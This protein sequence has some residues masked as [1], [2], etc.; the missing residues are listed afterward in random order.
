MVSSTPTPPGLP[1]LLIEAARSAAVADG[2]NPPIGRT[3]PSQPIGRTRPSQSVPPVTKVEEMS[4]NGDGDTVAAALAMVAAGNA[5]ATIKAKETTSINTLSSTQMTTQTKDTGNNS[6]KMNSVPQSSLNSSSLNTTNSA[7]PPP[8]QPPRPP[9]PA[10]VE[11]MP[12]TVSNPPSAGSAAHRLALAAATTS[13]TQSASTQ[14]KARPPPQSSTAPVRSNT[15]GSGGGVSAVKKKGPALRRGKWTSEEEAYANRLIAEFKGG[16]LPL[17]DGTT[18]R[19]FLSK[20][21]NCDPMRIS[22][23]FVGSNCI[24]KQVFRR[25]T[26][27]INRLTPEQIQQSRAELSELERRFLERVAQTNRLKSSGVGGGNSGNGNVPSTGSSSSLSKMKG[28]GG[29][30]NQ[31]ARNPPWLRTPNGFKHG[32]GATAATSALS[33]GTVNRA[34]L[35]GRAMLQTSGNAQANHPFVDKMSKGP[36]RSSGSAGILALMEMQRRQSQNN[37]LPNVSQSLGNAS[38]ASNLL[39]EAAAAVAES[40]KNSNQGNLSGPALAQIARNASAA[41]MAGL[42]AAGN[43]MT[44][45]MLKTGLSRNQLSQLAREHQRNSSTSISNMMERQ[46]SLD[47]LMS[48]DFQSL[49]SIDNLAN[50]IQTGSG[51]QVPRSG[52]KN[53][54]SDGNGTTNHLAT[55]AASINSANNNL[56]GTLPQQ[57]PS[58]SRMESL[59]RSLSGGALGNKLQNNGSA[60]NAT[61]NNLLQSVQGMN[62]AEGNNA[63]NLF[64]NAA[65][66]LNLA[67]MLRTDSST[68]LTALRMQDGLAQ[69]NSSVDDFLSLVA[70]GDIPHQDPHM[71]NVPLQSVLQH[72][73]QNNQ[74]GAQV[75]ATYLAQQQLL[76]QAANNADSSLGQKI[77]SLGGLGNNSSAAS[78][79]NQYTAS[80]NTNTAA[81][82]FA[83]QLQE[84]RAA[85][86]LA[87]ARAQQQNDSSGKRKLSDE[88]S[89]SFTDRRPSKR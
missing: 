52:M 3:R 33:S 1:S 46:S 75:A 31:S 65:S 23:K 17:T 8:P 48:L 61:F 18:L 67:N 21:L 10:K 42:A 6:Y 73:Q 34:A 36:L 64:G 69:R 76:A 4:R 74:S 49:Q 20:L 79:L 2:L 70:S 5:V 32:T 57:L 35:A 44:D 25:R 78:L 16:L 28:D 9:R 37:L 68:G 41:R 54:S 13:S 40:N 89:P 88:N 83:Q 56:N 45:L 80:Q 19:T 26:V 53:W 62:N 86:V 39:A 51:S 15:G 72:Q 14:P 82:A 85:S 43:S 22:K 55:V 60:S 47:A 81:A 58:E 63:P 77:A 7:P 38:S 66:A 59:I 29:M 50:L 87:A 27:D 12:S 30:R 24:G 71:L 84:A 11:P